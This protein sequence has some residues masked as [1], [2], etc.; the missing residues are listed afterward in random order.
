MF[1]ERERERGEHKIEYIIAPIERLFDLPYE[2]AGQL[3][4]DHFHQKFGTTRQK[5]LQN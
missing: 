4:A 2:A 5:F 3:P 1:R